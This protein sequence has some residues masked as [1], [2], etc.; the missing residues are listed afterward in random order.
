MTRIFKSFEWI[1]AVLSGIA[2]LVMMVLTFVD[3]VGRYGFNNSIFGAA[4]MIE[5]LMIAVI[6]AGI[7]FVTAGDQ[8]IKVEIFEPWIKRRWPRLQ[9]WSVLA[10][11]AVVYAGLSWELSHHAIDSF[12][13]GKRTAVLD[14]L[15]WFMPAAAAVFSAIGV[16][17]FCVAIIKTRGEPAKLGRIE[18]SPGDPDQTKHLEL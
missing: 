4:E 1:L 18:H 5:Y 17:L 3:V 14:M 2:L 13:S 6:F 8:H 10:F 16:L 12:R 7:A 15:Q 11:S 9:R